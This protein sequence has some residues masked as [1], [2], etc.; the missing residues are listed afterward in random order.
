MEP[1]LFDLDFQ[2]LHDALLTLIAV[3]TLFFF[4]SYFFFNPVREFLKK[5]QDR[6]KGEIEEASANKAEAEALKAEYEKK[7]ASIDKEAEAILSEARKKAVANENSIVAKAKEEASGIIARANTEAELEKQKVADDVKKE[8]INVASAL[9]ERVIGEKMDTDV[10]DHLVED[11]L[12][13][14]GDS[15]WLS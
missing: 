2:L 14:I 3:I 9:A 10:Q 1:R 8:M 11:T 13:E 6:I 15:T 5:R 12:K 4:A 7:L